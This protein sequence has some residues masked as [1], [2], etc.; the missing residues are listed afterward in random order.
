M[1]SPTRILPALLALAIGS[2]SASLI[3]TPTSITYTGT[4]VEAAGLNLDDENNIINGNGL[5][6]TPT[7]ANYTTVTHAA[8]SFAAP[9]NAWVTNDPG[10]PGSDY[11]AASGGATIVFDVFLDQAYSLTDFVSWGYHFGSPND[12]D[13]QGVT[14]DYGVGSFT[15]GSTSIVVP[16]AASPGAAV[17]TALGSTIQADRVRLTIT[18]NHFGT[19]GDGGDRVGFAEMRFVAVPEASEAAIACIGILG[20]AAHRRRKR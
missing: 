18:D 13:I 12:N 1:N 5:S 14:L 4:G 16:L 10:G 15:D 3:V 17:S 11:Y 6:A 19:S 7:F 9:G 8:V 2:A 20:L